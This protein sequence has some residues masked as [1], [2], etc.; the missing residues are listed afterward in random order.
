MAVKGLSQ[1]HH[2]AEKA[3]ACISAPAVGGG[4][5]VYSLYPPAVPINFT[6][7]HDSPPSDAPGWLTK[8]C[9][10]YRGLMR[11]TAGSAQGIVTGSVEAEQE[12]TARMNPF[13]NT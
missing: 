10:G 6:K 11:H 5:G 12:S 4:Y 13:I 3:Y 8:P 7:C 1:Q 9:G 2:E